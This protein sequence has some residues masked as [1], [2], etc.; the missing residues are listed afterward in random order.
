M[1][2]SSNQENEVVYGD[3]PDGTF[4]GRM[5]KSI[6][7][8]YQSGVRKRKAEG[9]FNKQQDFNN[10]FSEAVAKAVADYAEETLDGS[11][12]ARFTFIAEMSEL[13]DCLMEWYY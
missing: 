7:E 1:S 13:V 2:M 4:M 8:Y 9:T 12:S 6:D 3:Y 10:Y 5:V 11:D